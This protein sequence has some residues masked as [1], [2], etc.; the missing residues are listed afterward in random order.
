MNDIVLE[1]RELDVSTDELVEETNEV[2]HRLGLDVS[3]VHEPPDGSD[4]YKRLALAYNRLVLAQQVF[5]KPTISIWK[6]VA[7]DGRCGDNLLHKVED[8]LKELACA[9]EGTTRA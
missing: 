5:T 1:D 6:I 2:I 4:G 7:R 9:G 8:L 3:K